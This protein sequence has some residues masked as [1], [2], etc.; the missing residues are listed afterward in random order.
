MQ[1][2]N[3]IYGKPPPIQFNNHIHPWGHE[4]LSCVM[5]SWSTLKTTPCTNLHM[6][7]QP[8]LVEQDIGKICVNN[9]ETGLW[10]LTL[11]DPGGLGTLYLA[12]YI[13]RTML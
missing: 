8:Q 3:P 11:S 9:K 6:T 1:E 4:Y 5:V 2:N 13:A 7:D 12:R 10:R